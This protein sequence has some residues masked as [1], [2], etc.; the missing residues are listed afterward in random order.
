VYYEHPKQSDV[1]Y[2]IKGLI[3]K[4]NVQGFPL[5]AKEFEMRVHRFINYSNINNPSNVFNINCTSIVLHTNNNFI[6]C[7]LDVI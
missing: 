2:C 6:Q 4:Y 7:F 3:E 5:E 1:E